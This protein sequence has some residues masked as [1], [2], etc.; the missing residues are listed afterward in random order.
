MASKANIEAQEQLLQL[1]NTKNKALEKSVMVLS[2][3]LDTQ[4]NIKSSQ[5]DQV[6]TLQLIAQTNKSNASIDDK[7]V[8]LKPK[9][10][11]KKG[12]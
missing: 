1:L 9:S 8:K 3:E 10:K 7:I 2:A 5:K 4:N 12:K 11:K 6:K